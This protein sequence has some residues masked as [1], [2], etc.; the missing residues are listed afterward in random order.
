L[1]KDN[2]YWKKKVELIL[3]R[4][5]PNLILDWYHLYHKF[6]DSKNDKKLS[7]EEL[8]EL[9]NSTEDKNLINIL[10]LSGFKR[11]TKV[12]I[13]YD[14][15]FPT[16]LEDVDMKILFEFD[17]LNEI[18]SLYNDSRI[19]RLMLDKPRSFLR[20]KQRYHL[21][22]GYINSMKELSILQNEI[23][24]TKVATRKHYLMDVYNFKV[25]DRIIVRNID[26]RSSFDNYIVIEATGPKKGG[27]VNQIKFKN[28]DLFGN[29]LSD[30]IFIGRLYVN[31]QNAVWAWNKSHSCA[32]WNK[33]ITPG[34]VLYQDGPFIKNI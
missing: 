22:S 17:N 27:G 10:E 9:L 2:N 6:Y 4:K 26:N 8:I 15:N 19:I 33:N 28:I 3:E 11:K 16:G 21:N 20:V 7:N 24:K 25:G 32:R 23:T 30:E 18:V 12:E 13:L 34:I 29:V 31:G 5:F 1:Y 14:L